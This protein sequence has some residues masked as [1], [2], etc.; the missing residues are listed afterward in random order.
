MATPDGRSE[1]KQNETGL[2]Y[3]MLGF[4]D[5]NLSR[6]SQPVRDT[7]GVGILLILAIYVLNGLIGSTCI[8]GRLFVHN[9][10]R[11]PAAGWRVSLGDYESVTNAKGWWTL[12]LPGSGIPGRIKLEVGDPGKDAD[13]G[14]R[15]SKWVGED[16][17]FGP[18][19][20]LNTF[21]PMNNL[22]LDV[23]PSRPPGAQV[24]L[25]SLQFFSVKSVYA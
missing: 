10:E 4:L 1:G 6:F 25:S 5:R 17:T 14:S 22:V 8:R 18:W 24:Q 13:G 9:P 11:A 21:K 3:P 15:D 16:Y 20:F 7:I 12:P 2:I 23:Y 19:P